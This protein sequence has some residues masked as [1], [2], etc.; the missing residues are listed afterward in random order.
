LAAL[1][2]GRAGTG[3]VM[4][5]V[6]AAHE[7]AIWA[8]HEIVGAALPYD[9]PA[10]AAAWSGLVAA[11]AAAVAARATLR[12]ALL[13]PV[14]RA[15]C[16]LAAALLAYEAVAFVAGPRWGGGPAA[17]TQAALLKTAGSNGLTLV[18]LSLLHRLSICLGLARREAAAALGRDAHAA[19]TRDSTAQSRPPS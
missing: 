14:A 11:L 3:I 6:W 10:A 5:L 2:L 18:A 16:V 4:V 15:I 19:G 9:P 13:A 8:A 12:L 17:F 7:L 1:H